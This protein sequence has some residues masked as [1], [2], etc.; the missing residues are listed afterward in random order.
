MANLAEHPVATMTRQMVA[1]LAPFPGRLAITW[2]IA[3]LAALVATVAMFYELPDAAVSC[4]LVVLLMKPD[5]SESCVVAVAVIILITIVIALMVPLSQWTADSPPLRFLTIAAVS[6][7]LL[8]IGAA[9][10]LG[11]IGGILALIVA[12][13]LTLQFKAPGGDI[14]STALRYA[15]EMVA[16]PMAMMIGFSLIL[17]RSTVR[18]LRNTVL[19]RLTTARDALALPDPSQHEGLRDLLREGND[20]PA[21]RAGFTRRF[22][23]V[24]SSAAS[25]IETDIWASYQ[26]MLAVSAFPPNKLTEAARDTLAREIQDVIDALESGREPQVPNAASGADPAEDLIRDALRAIAGAKG[27]VIRP[28]PKQP[29]FSS[30]AFSNPDYPRFALKTTA[31]AMLCYVI[32]SGL[33]WQGI[34]TAMITCYVA[35]LGTTGE[36][37][38]KLAL[39]IAG[40]L[41]GAIM[42][43]GSILFLIPHMDSIGH[44]ALL[45]FSGS[46][47]AA[48]VASGNERISYA[49]I[50]IAMAFFLSILH[51]FG[52][53]LDLEVARDRI[54]G[55]LVGNIVVFL[56]STLILPVPLERRLRLNLSKALAGLAALATPPADRRKDPIAQAAAVEQSLGHVN[57]GFFLLPLEPRRLRPNDTTIR[58]LQQISA[59]A[60]ALNRSLYASGKTMPSSLAARLTALPAAILQQAEPSNN[61]H[62][63]QRSHLGTSAAQS[64]KA[65]DD[66]ETRIQRI[67]MLARA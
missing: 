21:K 29:F 23:L 51:G 2:R 13:V 66:F 35:S 22:H 67:E 44:L 12:V 56:I 5:G 42:G 49:G 11:E 46:F 24:P 3:L 18:L 26:L 33:N 61:L 36:T 31:A 1:D 45:V 25:Q 41:V 17:G 14:I 60:E 55:I 37:I 47:V 59:D 16:M 38:H 62:A 58:G 28:A 7:A 8:Y 32:Y 54:I 6:F 39:R 43:W 65:G 4:Y 40:C 64:T 9:S 57:D 34:H 63:W 52:P 50:Q 20:Q 30:D 53:S 48:W 27:K 19:Q 15:W 10:K